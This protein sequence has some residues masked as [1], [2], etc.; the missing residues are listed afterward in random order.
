MDWER[1]ECIKEREEPGKRTL[2]S[3]TSVE[4]FL[5]RR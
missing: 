4:R 2:N 3:V 1:A 5:C